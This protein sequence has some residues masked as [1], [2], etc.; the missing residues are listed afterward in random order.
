MI[1][2]LPPDQIIEEIFDLYKHHGH[3]DYIGEPVSQLEHMAQ[4]AEL[5]KK[6]GYD[7]E[8]IL[9]AFF[10]DIGHLCAGINQP[11]MN[12][13]GAMNHEELGAKFL[14]ERGF[15]DRLVFLVKGHVAAKRYL[16]YKFPEYLNKLS[17]ASKATLS[18]QGGIMSKQEAEKFEVNPDANVMLKMRTWDD[19]AKVTDMEVTNFD[20]IKDLALKHLL[21][22]NS[23][24][25]LQP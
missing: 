17:E 18:F 1:K 6:D 25:L 20:E 21:T 7:E 11:D 12:G 19:N 5:A 13:F 8:V 23:K 10:H 14:E 16:T 24:E 15:S 4:S 2:Q 3:L 9:A 22:Q